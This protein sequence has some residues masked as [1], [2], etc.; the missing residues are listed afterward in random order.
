MPAELPPAAP[1]RF[2]T[3]A[4]LAPAWLAFVLYLPT[5]SHGFVWDDI[6]FLVDMPN[7]RDPSLWWDAVRQPLFVSLDYFRP[8]P[9]LSFVAE[10]RLGA[11]LPFLFHLTNISLHAANTV[12]VVLLA[13]TVVRPGQIWPAALAGVLFAVHPALVENVAWISDRFDLLMVLLLLLILWAQQAINQQLWRAVSTGL[14]FFLALLCKETSVVVLALLPVW[15]F[16]HALR[17]RTGRL[18]VRA[19]LLRDWPTALS[20]VLTLAM[21]LAVRHHSLGYLYVGDAQMT[22]G[23]PLQHLL[24]IGKT[25]GWYGVLAG[26]PFG[27]V[28]AAHPGVTPLAA[29]DWLAWAGLTATALVIAL[30][31]IRIT[32]SLMKACD[33]TT[34]LLIALALLAL[35]PVSNLVPLTIGDNLV[36]DRYLIMPLAFVAMAAARLIGNADRRWYWLVALA[37]CLACAGAVCRQVPEWEN[38][39]S[40]WSAAY[41]RTPQSEIAQQNY[42]AALVTAGHYDDTEQLA[43]RLLAA[44]AQASSVSHNL[45]L[46]QALSGKPADAEATLSELLARPYTDTPFNRLNRSEALNLL[47]A[48]LIA[49][50]RADAAAAPLQDAIALTPHLGRPYHH[51]ALVRYAQGDIVLGDQ[52]D[53]LAARRT[54]AAI[55]DELQAKRREARA[56]AQARG[57]HETSQ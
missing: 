6:Y 27:Q 47:G 57:G 54:H 52:L 49:Q 48:V 38:N 4:V 17:G 46:A 31:I 33:A 9:L 53:E 36:S 23:T 10:V 50:G 22:P 15:N 34:P 13:R 44:G 24:L 45:A 51:L 39:L 56:A 11:G 2:N 7:L 28:N 25:L 1:S 29:D 21:Y 19:V 16:M 5:L 43:T 20:L 18:A 35:A 32:R 55:A 8:L 40:L 41:A 3:L 37:W 26:W 42:L 30:I 12:L 14:L